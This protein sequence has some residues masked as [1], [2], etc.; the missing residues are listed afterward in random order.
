MFCFRESPRRIC[1]GTCRQSRTPICYPNGKLARLPYN[2]NTNWQKVYRKT[3]I[4]LLSLQTRPGSWLTGVSRCGSGLLPSLSDYADSAFL[5][6]AATLHNM[7]RTA[8]VLLQS[9]EIAATP[10]KRNSR[11]M[12]NSVEA[13][14]A[15]YQPEF[16]IHVVCPTIVFT[17][18]ILVPVLNDSSFVDDSVICLDYANVCCLTAYRTQHY[19]ND[20]TTLHAHNT[21]MASLFDLYALASA[22]FLRQIYACSASQH[23]KKS[24]NRTDK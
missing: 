8:R 15:G 2:Q 22:D 6:L 11:P 3:K 18:Q 9:G 20:V 23:Q 24:C 19:C 10:V 17:N 12:A 21:H 1:A 7:I 4:L 16:T 14:S 5:R 13:S